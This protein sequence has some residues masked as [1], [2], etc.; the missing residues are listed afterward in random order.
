M[1]AHTHEISGQVLR[2]QTNNQQS[3]QSTQGSFLTLF[4]FP[5]GTTTIQTQQAQIVHQT[6]S[7]STTFTVS[8]LKSPRFKQ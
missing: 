2:K 7:P 1:A 5:Q 3:K 4:F 6:R 8:I